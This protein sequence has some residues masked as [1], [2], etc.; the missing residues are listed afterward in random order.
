MHEKS[1][2][3]DLSFEKALAR[4]EEILETM[5]LPDTPLEEAVRLFEESDK[6]IK[7][8]NECLERAGKRVE[9]LMKSRTGELLL[10]AEG[11]PVTADFL[12]PLGSRS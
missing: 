10:D 12:P 2:L 11:R 9:I 8:S 3:P 5:T 7:F 4:L 6:L 1:P